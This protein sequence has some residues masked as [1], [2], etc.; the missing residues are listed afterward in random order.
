MKKTLLIFLTLATLNTARADYWTYL[1]LY[2]NGFQMFDV[3]KGMQQQSA[4]MMLGTMMLPT[5]Q[6]IL[7]TEMDKLTVNQKELD[8]LAEVFDNIGVK[9]TSDSM[10]GT[11]V[12]LDQAIELGDVTDKTLE[13]ALKQAQALGLD[14]TQLQTMGAAAKATARAQAFDATL[15]EYEQMGGR[16]MSLNE[17]STL[18]AKIQSLADEQLNQQILLKVAEEFAEASKNEQKLEAEQIG[19]RVVQGAALN[20]IDINKQGDDYSSFAPAKKLEVSP[21]LYDYQ[22]LGGIRRLNSLT[23]QG[24]PTNPATGQPDLNGLN[25][26]PYV[27]PALGLPEDAPDVSQAR[28]SRTGSAAICFDGSGT[29]HPAGDTYLPGTAYSPGGQPLNGDVTK[30]VVVNKADYGNVAMGSK[31]YVYNNTTG[32]GTWAIAG[33]RGPNQGVS[34]MSTATANAIG[35]QIGRNSQGGYANSCSSDQVSYYFY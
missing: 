30:Y 24:V 11:V 23:S 7:N 28:L 1:Y 34:E 14:P 15:R 20:D 3:G 2:Y 25:N 35:V 5:G 33:D 6:G 26:T 22:A 13:N 27:D 16:P 9:A 32:M 29:S 18:N 19:R 21:G 17:R 10:G 31:V 8:N 12:A 4:N